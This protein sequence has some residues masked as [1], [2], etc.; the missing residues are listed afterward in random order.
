MKLSDRQYKLCTRTGL[1]L[2]IAAALAYDRLSTN[3][4]ATA[5]VVAVVGALIGFFPLVTSHAFEAD[6]E[7]CHDDEN[8]LSIGGTYQDIEQSNVV[9]YEAEE[10][11]LSNRSLELY[12]QHLYSA[13]ERNPGVTEGYA[14]IYKLT[15]TILSTNVEHYG[16]SS[17]NVERD[18]AERVQEMHELI[19]GLRGIPQAFSVELTS[20]NSIIVH[21]DNV[22]ESGNLVQH[23]SKKWGQP[24]VAREETVH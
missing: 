15:N 17:L 6:D 19:H 12:M 4:Q 20:N 11:H 18:R 24:S 22:K 14:A 23:F 10:T 21:C 16:L 1:V 5:L 9:V 7:T 2:A 3:Y 13:L 8:A